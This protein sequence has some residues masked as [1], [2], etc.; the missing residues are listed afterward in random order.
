MSTPESKAQ[1]TLLMDAVAEM[2]LRNRDGMV[3]DAK[4]N[5]Q[6][7]VRVHERNI[8]VEFADGRV[9]SLVLYGPRGK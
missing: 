3:P 1:D 9:V 7:Y 2:L 6:D 8:Q 5:V 4:F